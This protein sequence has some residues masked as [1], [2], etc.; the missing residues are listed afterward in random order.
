MKN[1]YKHRL[2]VRSCG[3]LIEDNKLLLVELQS[4]V[5]DKWTWIPPGGGVEFGES[6]EQALIR[7]FKEETGLTVS[8]GRRVHVNEVISPPIHAIEF[9]FL[10]N[11]EEGELQL[12]NDPEMTEDDQILNDI[13]FFSLTQ[14]QEMEVAPDFLKAG[15]SELLSV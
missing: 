14:M 1:T 8:V 5:T 12:G 6:L 11:R 3:L 4:P 15:I 9:Y 7:E 10:V 13:G 2:R